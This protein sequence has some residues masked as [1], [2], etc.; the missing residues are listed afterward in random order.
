MTAS[1]E[2]TEKKLLAERVQERLI[3][4]K[5]S[6]L[7]SDLLNET[8]P[9]FLKNYL[10]NSVK[11]MVNTEE[12]VQFKNSKRF[13]FDHPKIKQLRN[14]L[15]QAFEEVT[16]FPREELIEAINKTVRLQFDL[17]VRPSTTLMTIFY[18]NKSDRTKN[19]ILQILEALHDDRV[20]LNEVIAKIKGFDQFHVVEA[21]FRKL[22]TETET[23]IYKEKFLDVF[24]SEVKTFIKFLGMIHGFNSWEI[25]LEL[26]KLLLDERNLNGVAQA[27]AHYQ[28]SAIDIADL[29][30]LLELFIKEKENGPGGNGG[31]ESDNFIMYSSTNP[32]V[33][34]E[35]I[36]VVNGHT[37]LDSTS[38]NNPLVEPVAN[39]KRKRVQI[40]NSHDQ[41]DDWIIDRT[42]IEQRP[43][44]PLEP[45]EKLIDEKS[46]KFIVKK[47]FDQDCSAYENFISRLNEIDNWK[48][49]KEVIEIEL[50][51]RHVMP[52][53]REALRL[54]DL[55]FTRYFPEKQ[56]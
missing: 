49:A 3:G 53:S 31:D 27:F 9:T 23:E 7:Y 25:K 13:D 17:I 46:R 2:E 30:H 21:D 39:E 4:S 22:L 14:S 28:S 32:D 51:Q 16:I 47:I 38:A 36:T 44:G 50:H 56:I 8:I 6:V 43:E 11:R 18:R 5:N 29:K 41:A 42:K 37:E 45:L 12:P 20:Y 52:F 15:L 48:N 40:I 35:R 10:Q 33:K 54:G 19:E 24:L 55:A 1:I 26:V 34:T